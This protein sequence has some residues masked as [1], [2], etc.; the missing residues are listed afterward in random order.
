MDEFEI[1]FDKGVTDGLPVVPPTPPPDIDVVLVAPDTENGLAIERIN[2]KSLRRVDARDDSRAR[3]HDG[4]DCR[5]SP[6]NIVPV[7]PE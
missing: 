1:W 4:A 7:E 6:W 2:M 3:L 5:R